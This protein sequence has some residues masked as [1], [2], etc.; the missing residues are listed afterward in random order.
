MCTAVSFKTKNH[1]FGRNL[2]FEYSYKEEIT[3]TPR[4]YP[5]SFRH[6]T[7]FCSHFAM[8]G[9]ATID[10]GYPLY[11]DATNEKGLS[12]AGLYFPENAVYFPEKEGAHNIASFEF[13]PFILCQCAD[14]KQAKAKLKGINLTNTAYSEKY[15]VSPLHWIIADKNSSLTVEQT[16]NG[17]SVFENPVGVLTNNPPFEYHLH[18][19]SN[20]INLTSEEPTNR[21]APRVSIKPYSRGMGAIGLPGD[22]SSASRFIRASFVK[23]NSVCEEDEASSISQFF[24]ILSSVAQQEGCAKVE[25]GYEKTIY[26]SCCNTDRGIYYYTTYQNSQ[27]TGVSMNKTDIDGKRLISFPLKTEQQIKMEN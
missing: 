15:P 18:N 13:I 23:L 20:F 7:E 10:N 25:S 19:L 16:A 6:A 4:N 27:I 5:L 8:I 22:L 21:F 14:I 9:M 2:D 3:I 12:M 17:L 26:S 24:H 11:Y 1:Y